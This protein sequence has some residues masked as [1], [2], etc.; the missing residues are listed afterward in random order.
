MKTISFVSFKIA[1]SLPL[2]TIAH[3]FK[4]SKPLCRKQYILLTEEH[5][6]ITLKYNVSHKRVYLFD[7]GCVT[8]VNFGNDEIRVFIQYLESIVETINYTLFAKFFETH[9]IT[10]TEQNICRLFEASEQYMHYD[11]NISDIAAVV[12]AK[13][14][15]LNKMEYDLNELMDKYEIFIINLQNGNLRLNPIKSVKAIAQILKIEC[16]SI[17]SIKIFDRPKHK[18]HLLR[19]NKAYDD[20][21]K[22]F[23]FEDRFNIVQNKL[24]DLRNVINIHSTVGL[25]QNM[26]NLYI[27]EIILLGFFPLSYV[28]RYF[29]LN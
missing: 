17:S 4:I 11:D 13:S 5:I 1:P 18:D 14:A 28:I 21:A 16:N 27:L 25:R 24:S 15:A 22:Y 12:L 29:K 19:L 23:E 26:Q 6:S 9:T 3:F 7:F 10:V 8:F 20:L 2:S